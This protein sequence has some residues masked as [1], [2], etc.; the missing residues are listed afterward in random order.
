MANTATA[1]ATATDTDADEED[2]ALFADRC[3]P[4][5]WRLRPMVGKVPKT[6]RSRVV[7]RD[8]VCVESPHSCSSSMNDPYSGFPARS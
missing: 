6:R 7:G 3:S 2:D 8:E 5:P 4:R 1:T